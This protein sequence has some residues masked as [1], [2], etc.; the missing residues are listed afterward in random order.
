VIDAY[1][2]QV[3]YVDHIAPVWRALGSDRGTLHVTTP[4]LVERARERGVQAMIGLPDGSRPVLVASHRD[5]LACRGPIVLLE[6]GAGQH[7]GGVDASGRG[8]K[9]PRV[10]LYLGPNPTVA[11]RMAAVLPRAE[12]AVVGCPR[13]D[14]W[15]GYQPDRTGAPVVGLA[16]HW[17]ARTWPESRW[18]YPHYRPIL[19]EI[20]ARW[21]TIGH[22]HP[23]HYGHLLGDYRRA[24]IGPEH[25]PERFVGRVDLV[26]ADNTSLMWE[27]AA[28]G[29]P[30]VICD[31]PWYRRH[32]DHGL[33]YWRWADI[34]PRV[35][36]PAELPAAVER[37]WEERDAYAP[38][39]QAMTAEVYGRLDGLA[40]ARAAMAILSVVG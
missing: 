15:S 39:R 29:R 37:A 23:R 14:R 19:G 38:M 10:I 4:R 27:Y 21:T 13:L 36:G 25:D 6:H 34:G 17:D 11:D 3:Q 9:R 7:Y 5:E 31:A 18:A 26:V 16:W 1:A 20:A 24:G 28:T 22:G 2:S 35:S 30:V 12:L 8:E 40:S 33:R 32:V